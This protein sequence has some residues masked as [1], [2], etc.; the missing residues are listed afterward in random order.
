MPRQDIDPHPLGSGVVHSMAFKLHLLC[1]LFLCSKIKG[2][3]SN[4]WLR[5]SCQAVGRRCQDPN[6]NLPKLSSQSPSQNG[7]QRYQRFIKWKLASHIYAVSSF[8]NSAL[9]VSTD[10]SKVASEK[11]L[12]STHSLPITPQCREPCFRTSC[13]PHSGPSLT[14]ICCQFLFELCFTCLGRLLKSSF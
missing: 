5:R 2:N 6:P 14:H 11:T 7:P 3:V 9:H 4:T 13:R 12:S 10:F 8:L 1:N